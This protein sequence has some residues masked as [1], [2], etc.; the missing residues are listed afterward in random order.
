MMHKNNAKLRFIFENNGERGQLIK[1][2]EEL[3]ELEEE[4]EAI[5][6]DSSELGNDDFLSEVADVLVMCEQFRLKYNKVNSIKDYKINRQIARTKESED[7]K[8]KNV[9]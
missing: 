3:I 4:I 9:K 8:W 5:L 7:K 1:L 2:Q 6:C